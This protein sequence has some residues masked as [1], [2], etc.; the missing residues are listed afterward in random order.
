MIDMELITRIIC[1]LSL[2]CTKWAKHRFSNHGKK[3]KLPH[4]QGCTGTKLC[5]LVDYIRIHYVCLT[6]RC[7]K[8]IKM[9]ILCEDGHRI[10]DSEKQSLFS[11][12]N[13]FV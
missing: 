12:K 10:V 2:S 9:R 5:M 13:I 8:E 6:P 7:T 4:V 1:T 11:L 3:Q